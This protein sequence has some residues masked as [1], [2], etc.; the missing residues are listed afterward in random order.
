MG[1]GGGINIYVQGGTYLD[2]GGATM[3]ANALATQINRQIKLKN[4]F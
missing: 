1:G 4:F 2:Q 3:I